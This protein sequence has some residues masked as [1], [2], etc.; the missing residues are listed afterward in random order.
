MNERM[1]E[2]MTGD[3]LIAS[4]FAILSAFGFVVV[5]VLADREGH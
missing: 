2:R 4:S 1:N 5:D 3:L